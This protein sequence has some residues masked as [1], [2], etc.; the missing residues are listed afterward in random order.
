[1]GDDPDS[2]RSRLKVR[3][4]QRDNLMKLLKAETIREWWQIIR[5]FTDTKPR[6]PQVTVEQLRDVFQVR[7][8]PPAVMPDHFDAYLKHLRDLMAGAI[9]DR[10]LDDTP[11]A[12]F[13]APFVMSDMERMKKKLRSRSTKSA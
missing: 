2:H 8:N 10:T 5:S 6:A 7:L 9:P 3:K 11:E 4:I 12:F 1:L 13:S